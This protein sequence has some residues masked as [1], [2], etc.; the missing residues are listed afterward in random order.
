MNNHESIQT[1]LSDIIVHLNAHRETIGFAESCTGGGLTRLFALVPGVSSVLRGGIVSYM[2]EVKSDVLHVS[3][4]IMTRFG[5]VS[6]ETAIS[7]ALGALRV[8]GADWAAATT[9]YAGPGGG[10][11]RYPVGTVCFAVVSPKHRVYHTGCL[12]LDGDRAD[13]MMQ[14]AESVVNAIS[15]RM[16]IL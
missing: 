16:V 12:H 14:A 8:L 13:I 15:N 3:R 1:H 7:M 11:E 6:R 4:E 10:D 2:P 5:I 9:G